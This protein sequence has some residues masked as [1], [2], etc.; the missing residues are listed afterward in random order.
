MRKKAT[1]LFLVL[2]VFAA[3]VFAAAGSTDTAEK[4]EL[5]RYE[6]ESSSVR[7]EPARMG[8]QPGLAAIFEGTDD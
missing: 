6:A 4:V 8:T 1:V 3:E 2:C 7:L 5:A